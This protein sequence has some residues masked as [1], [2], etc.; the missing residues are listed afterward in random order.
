MIR[1]TFISTFATA[2][3]GAGIIIGMSSGADAM[4]YKKRHHHNNNDFSIRLGLYPAYGYYDRRFSVLDDH[5]AYEDDCRYRRVA[6]KKWNR[7][8]THRYIVYRK[9]LVCY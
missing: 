9:R 5:Y 1:K 8:H 7:S 6:I 3:L 4:M 2:I